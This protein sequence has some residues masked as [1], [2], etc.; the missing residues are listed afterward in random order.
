M[1]TFNARLTRPGGFSL[2]LAFAGGPGVTAL[3][4]ASGCGKSTALRLIAGLERP[5]FGRISLGERVLVDT[6][7]RQ[8][9]PP[10]RRRVGLVFQ[11]AQLFPHLSVRSNLLYGR[12]FS[13][14]RAGRLALDRVVAVLGLGHL[15]ARRPGTLSGG[16]RQRV[17][18]GR[19][20]LAEPDLVLMDE[21]LA[22]LDGDRK[23]EILPF[24]EALRTSFAV[25]IVY[26]SHAVEEVARL[27]EHVVRMEGGRAVA[28]GPP[29]AVL[30]PAALAA[31]A[32]RF[33]AVS[34]LSADVDR[35]LPDYGVTL[36]RHPAGTLVVPGRIEVGGGEGGAAAVRVAIR[37]TS[38]TL[39]VGRPGNISVR[40][41]LAGRVTRLDRNDGPFVLATLTLEGGEQLACYTTRLAMDALGLDVGDDVLAL[42]KAVAIDERGVPGLTLVGGQE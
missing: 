32:D 19:A 6:A 37:A 15:L 9:T 17:A 30:G 18:I 28:A 12:W 4:G 31:A 22:S 11:D 16:E 8:F 3:F 41:H 40:T 7:Q 10:H 42:V 21:P 29:A 27:A 1:I 33:A 38:V 36:L 26:V 2:A 23:L 14:A 5:D 24:I 20:L 39:A 35:F 13:G 25:P 34:V